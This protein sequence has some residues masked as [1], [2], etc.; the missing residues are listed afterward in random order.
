[1]WFENFDMTKHLLKTLPKQGT[2][3]GSGLFLCME[4]NFD[5]F[6]V[7]V[8]EL[9]TMTTDG[10]AGVKDIRLM[11]HEHNVT[12]FCQARILANLLSCRSEL[13]FSL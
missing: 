8:S 3:L 13:T 5:H 7:D 10:T 9:V 4:R 6:K 12:R 1:M 2:S 11:K